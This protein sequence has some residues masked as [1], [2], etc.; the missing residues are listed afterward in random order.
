LKKCEGIF[1]EF[2]KEFLENL[3]LLLNKIKFSKDEV[4]FCQNEI[5]KDPNFYFIEDGEI[6]LYIEN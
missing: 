6:Q 5:E 1:S 3:C 2:S 4:L